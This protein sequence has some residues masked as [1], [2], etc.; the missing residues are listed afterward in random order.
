[1]P[2]MK[3]ASAV[4]PPKAAKEVPD[5]E[6]AIDESDDAAE[7]VEAPDEDDQDVDLSKDKYIKK[8]KAKKK[9]PAKSGAKAGAKA[10]K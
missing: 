5:L 10:K 9:A 8:P 2:F 7:L 3:A 4:A 6:E 1:M